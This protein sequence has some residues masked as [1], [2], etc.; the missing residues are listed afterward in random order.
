MNKK[1][2]WSASYGRKKNRE[3]KNL[4]G[5]V[6]KHNSKNWTNNLEVLYP[7]SKSIEQW[8][9][10]QT[11]SSKKIEKQTI[12]LNKNIKIAKILKL[13][14]LRQNF[15]SLNIPI[16]KICLKLNFVSEIAAALYLQ[17]LK[18]FIGPWRS[19]NSKMTQNF[20]KKIKSIANFNEIL[21]KIVIFLS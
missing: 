16:S 7:A 19:I 2:I 17:G 13:L 3:I 18:K 1:Q 9:P 11:K 12:K 4:A 8:Q 14:P 15:I 5:Q 20:F 6:L 10:K 21:P